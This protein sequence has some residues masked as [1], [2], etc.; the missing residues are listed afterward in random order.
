MTI[1]MTEH[2]RSIQMQNA[3]LRKQN[4]ELRLRLA[5]LEVADELHSLAMDQIPAGPEIEDNFRRRAELEPV[6]VVR[7]CKDEPLKGRGVF[8]DA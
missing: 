2:Q 7:E 3:V 4:K 5:D 6:L 8:T 1:A